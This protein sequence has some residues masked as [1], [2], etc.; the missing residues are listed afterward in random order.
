[1]SLD[2]SHQLLSCHKPKYILSSELL[3]PMIPPGGTVLTPQILLFQI[4]PS[5]V[6]LESS[7]FP[8]LSPEPMSLPPL[9]SNHVGSSVPYKHSV[10]RYHRS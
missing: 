4:L 6:R 8:G 7:L 2:L 5:Q 9:D 1:M 3:L 10:G